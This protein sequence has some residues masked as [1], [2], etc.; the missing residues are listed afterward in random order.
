MK[1]VINKILLIIMTGTLTLMIIS[2]EDEFQVKRS[3]ELAIL[4][5]TEV[6]VGD[7]NSFQA[8]LFSYND[9][10][11]WS[12][13]VTGPD[14][15]PASG[16]GEYFDVLFGSLGTYT[17]TL[18]ESNR[19]GSIEVEA[20]S[21]ELSLDEYYEEVVEDAEETEIAIPIT[22]DNYV[23]GEIT[24][25]YSLSGTAVEGVDYELL[26]PNPLVIDASSDDDEYY[27]YINLLVDTSPEAL[28][29][30][31]IVTVNSLTTIIPN[32]VIL[33]DETDLLT[34]TISIIDDLKEVGFRELINVN[35]AEPGVIPFEI[36]LSD[37][38]PVDITVNY[39]I[40]G[41]GVTDATPDGPNS[42]TF[43]PGETSKLIYI[44]FNAGAFNDPQDVTVTLTSL[45][46]V[47]T[48]TEINGV[49]DTKVFVIQ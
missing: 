37:D 26:S 3:N 35:V 21:K 20:I 11:T 10:R 27:I 39:S 42:V 6:Y 45:T 31:I 34:A 29:K 48:E 18:S 9:T 12:W 1:I 30:E 17:I 32:E 25:N 49:K 2:C 8:P 36:T 16:D 44:Q 41:T 28:S 15:S 7:E 23:A 22:I 46:T 14:A 47:D 38:A 19:E 24:I 33:S 4:G 13:T 43:A 5:P 40:A